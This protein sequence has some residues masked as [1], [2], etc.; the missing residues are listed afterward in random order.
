MRIR[1]KFRILI[2]IYGALPLLT[3]VVASHYFHFYNLEGFQ[4][5]LALGWLVF[6][7]ILVIP[8]LGLDWLF[9]KQFRTITRHC[10]DIK[11]GDYTYFE[12]PNQPADEMEENEL[13]FLM[14]QMNWMTKKIADRENELERRVE[15]RT[16]ELRNAN[17]ELLAAKEAADASA[18]TKGEFL[19]TMSH[20]IRTPMNAIIG[21]G[22]LLIKSGLND[23]QK[24]YMEIIRN[25]SRSLMR[26]IDDVLDYSKIDAGKIELEEVPFSPRE[27]IREVVELFQVKAG[28]KGIGLT[29]E[30]NPAVPA[31]V[32]GDI[33]R[34]RQILH[35]F[36]SN[37]V[38]FTSQGEVRI[39]VSTFS[40]GENE[41]GLSFCVRDTGIGMSDETQKKIFNA[42]IQADSSTTRQ[43]GGSGLGMSICRQLAHLMNGKV[44]VRSREGTGSQFF[45][46]IVLQRCG[47]DR[48]KESAQLKVPDCQTCN[49]KMKEILV[50]DDNLINRKV[51]AELLRDLGLTPHLA[52][53][54]EEAIRIV[55][56]RSFDMV[57]MDIRMENMDGFEAARRIKA[58]P[59][60][61]ERPIVALTGN[62]T[63]RE[64]ITT[65]ESDIDDYLLKP[66]DSKRLHAMIHKWAKCVEYL[67]PQVTSPYYSKSGDPEIEPELRDLEGIDIKKGLVRWRGKKKAYYDMIVH[68]SREFRSVMD[69]IE[70]AIVDDDPEQ[71]E[72]LV[73]KAKGAA[74]TISANK[75]F[76]DLEQLE[77]SILSNRSGAKSLSLES[78]RRSLA[79]VLMSADKVNDLLSQKK[80]SKKAAD[81]L[82]NRKLAPTL[83]KLDQS[84]AQCNLSSRRYFDEARELLN[85]NELEGELKQLEQLTRNFE[86]DEARQVLTI[87][88]KKLAVETNRTGDI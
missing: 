35:N 15:R 2:L 1:I 47:C 34:V 57:L 80:T 33:L 43:Y 42:F 21:L 54:G 25:S 8:L 72:F 71:A 49:L 30:L 44:Y 76:C 18:K 38:K 7:L 86:F 40:E 11:N 50:V 67:T 45:F 68:F 16:A 81:R 29:M 20:E 74:G 6:I 32:R 19:A 13:T 46:D 39:S 27:L 63:V 12:L 58:L 55:G 3:V 70:S 88:K 61:K 4:T 23:K 62:I 51:S 82:A 66:L 52:V 79:I 41:T 77:T 17:R 26:I 78:G 56:E 73:H 9:F 36:T 64:Q 60:M 83:Q 59:D 37:A 22:D 31:R 65:G 84:L 14:R 48:L 28:E 69:Q 53:S 87:I 24:E 85:G 75:L 5:G 10:N